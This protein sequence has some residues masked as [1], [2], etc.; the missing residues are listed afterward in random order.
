VEQNTWRVVVVKDGEATLRQRIRATDGSR[1]EKT[2]AEKV[3][4][5]LGLEPVKKQGK[6]KANKGVLVIP[7]NFGVALTKPEPVIV[8]FHKVWTRLSELKEANGGKVPVVLRN[9]QIIRVTN[10]KKF[11]GIW[12]VFSAKNN[13]TGIALDRF[14]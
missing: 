2:I 4:K 5:L 13:A 10:G 14:N 6:L 11:K 9:G 1:P 8:P 7:D 3:T 12:R